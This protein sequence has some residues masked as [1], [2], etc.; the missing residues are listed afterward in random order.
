MANL[1]Q[2]RGGVKLGSHSVITGAKWMN[3]S[4]KFRIV[5]ITVVILGSFFRSSQWTA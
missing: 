5:V 1:R 4:S 3:L 2:N